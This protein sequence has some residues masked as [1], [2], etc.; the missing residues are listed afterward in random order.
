MKV[1]MHGEINYQMMFRGGW[2]DMSNNPKEICDRCKQKIKDVAIDY[3]NK[4][5][6]RKCFNDGRAVKSD[7]INSNK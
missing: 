5:L 3:G 1:G 6:C 7:E 2:K 4:I